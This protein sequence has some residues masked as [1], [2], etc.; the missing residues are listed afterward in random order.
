MES[1]PRPYEF[2]PV[3][4]R[5]LQT[6]HDTVSTGSTTSNV[7]ENEQNAVTHL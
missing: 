1:G 2:Q 5:R 3:R 7:S 6:E 4:R